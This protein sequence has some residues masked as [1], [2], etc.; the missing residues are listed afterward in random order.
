M[1]FHLKLKI[2]SIICL[3][4]HDLKYLYNFLKKI[5]NESAKKIHFNDSYRIRKLLEI[6]FQIMKNL[7]LFLINVQR[8]FSTL[9]VLIYL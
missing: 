3:K 4:V 1:K 6:F 2:K 8:M 9:I 7:V 5:D